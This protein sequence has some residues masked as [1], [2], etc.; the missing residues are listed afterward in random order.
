MIAATGYKKKKTPGT[1]TL[2]IF[3]RDF[4]VLD[5]WVVR[6]RTTA[7]FDKPERRE[8]LVAKVKKLVEWKGEDVGDGWMDEGWC[9]IS[10]S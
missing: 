6:M 2:R 7:V 4:R 9:W 10:R 1:I 8:E 5:E 3:V